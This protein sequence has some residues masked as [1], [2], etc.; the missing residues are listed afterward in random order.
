MIARRAILLMIAF[1]LGAPL[2][3]QAQ[4]AATVLLA[5]PLTGRSAVPAFDSLKQT[6]AVPNFRLG[7]RY[8]LDNPASYD[9]GGA[10]GTTLESLGAGPLKV[11]YIAVG[12][13]RRDA[14]GRIT[15]AVVIPTTIPA[16][17]PTCTT[18]GCG[19]WRCRVAR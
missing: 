10:G 4:P 16:T 11:S 15:N 6:V 9:Q 8:D 17:A 19:A 12:T 18:S 1:A 7:G 13:P 3:S 5:Q 14:Q 2:A